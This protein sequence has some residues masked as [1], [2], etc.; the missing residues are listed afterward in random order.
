MAVGV[1]I[2]A[3]QSNATGYPLN[4]DCTV[5]PD[6]TVQIYADG[7]AIDAGLAGALN[8][9]A[10]GYGG[11]ATKFG[12]E[13][14][15]AAEL[16]RLEPAT[17]WKIVKYTEPGTD[18]STHWAHGTAGHTALLSTVSDALT[19]I[20]A[21][22]LRG[23]AWMQGESDSTYVDNAVRYER[24]L[25]ALVTDLR[26]DLSVSDLP[27]AVG[28][29]AWHADWPFAATVRAGQDRTTHAL[30]AC[31]I[32]ETT[33]LGMLPGEHHYDAPGTLELGRRFARAILASDEPREF[34]Y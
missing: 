2:L 26:S 29:I 14:G 22:T 31:R 9:L 16:V 30:A 6:A 20:G 21:A 1:V 18:I 11:D 32:V 24:L 10:L 25:R 8:D 3:G 27:F 7:T 23:F 12:P 17:T 15:L 13:I 4:V 19:A 28:R 5:T 34:A 33:D